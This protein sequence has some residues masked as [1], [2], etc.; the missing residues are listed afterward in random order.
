MDRTC[1]QS[2]ARPPF[3]PSNC[4]DTTASAK[5][6]TIKQVESL[7]GKLIASLKAIN[8][9]DP[10]FVHVPKTQSSAPANECRKIDNN[11]PTAGSD[12]TKDSRTNNTKDFHCPST[13][14]REQ[15]R[16]WNLIYENFKQGKFPTS[17]THHIEQL[18]KPATCEPRGGISLSP[19]AKK[20]FD[21][22]WEA[23]SESAKEEI[24][25]EEMGTSLQEAGWADENLR[26][27]KLEDWSTEQ[28]RIELASALAGIDYSDDELDSE[29]DTDSDDEDDF[30]HIYGKTPSSFRLSR[31][32]LP[33][34]CSTS[35]GTFDIEQSLTP[36]LP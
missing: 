2:R 27:T 29:S 21:T 19:A 20:S 22:H 16:A 35:P 15:K 13:R 24:M 36:P 3:T 7:A 33:R 8:S 23:K 18:R 30:P 6:K 4:N 26:R 17:P 5:R 14:K 10:G 1:S 12:N 11:S 9:Q 34:Q 31:E 28:E 25:D 32:F